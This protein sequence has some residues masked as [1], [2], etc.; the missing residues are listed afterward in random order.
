MSDARRDVPPS[1]EEI[2]W[3]THDALCK[4]GYANLTM[5]NI[6]A[7]CSKS[8]SLLTYHYDTKENLIAAYLEFLVEQFDEGG[9][10]IDGDDP[11]ERLE[12][13]LDFFTVGSDVYSE[14]LAV[15]FFELGNAALRDEGFRE[16][17]RT[18]EAGN[19]RI[20]TDI[21]ERGQEAGRFRGDIDADDVAKLLVS[22]LAGAGQL[23]MAAGM[24]GISA[25]VREL[26]RTELLP[27]LLFADDA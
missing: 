24:T 10:L 1:H 15:A 14:E 12:R 2:M 22:T 23:E 11:M 13:F 27:E 9:D 26:V 7:E 4:H 20:L 21:V 3:A 17:L 6:A 16:T 25:D 5:R 18:H 8:H 19:L